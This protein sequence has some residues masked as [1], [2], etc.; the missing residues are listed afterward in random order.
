MEVGLGEGALAPSEVDYINAHGTSTPQGDVAETQAIRRVFGERAVRIPVSST[1]SMTGHALGAAGAIQ[2][3]PTVPA[4]GPGLLPPTAK[5]R[6]PLPSPPPPYPPPPPP[7]PHITPPPHPS[8][9]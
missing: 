9:H 3:A 7:P 5:H 4:V 1:K 8:P 2:S 6:R